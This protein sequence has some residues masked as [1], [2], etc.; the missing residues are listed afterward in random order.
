[1]GCFGGVLKAHTG[2]AEL[3]DRDHPGIFR[4]SGLVSVCVPSRLLRTRE[5]TG[6]QV[7]LRSYQHLA[8]TRTLELWASGTQRV[9]VTMPTGT[10]KTVVFSEVVKRTVGLG[11]RAIVLAHRKELIEQAAKTIHR[12]AGVTCDIEMAERWADDG[13]FARSPVVA[14]SKDTLRRRRLKRFNPA[15][16]GC[17]IIDEC[18]HA[19]AATYQDQIDHFC[20]NP[21]C[22]LLG[23]TATPDRADEIALGNVFQDV[24]LD[25]QMRDAIEDGWLV[26]VR[27]RP[28]DVRNID[29]SSVHTQNGDLSESEL[30]SAI[31]RDRPVQEMVQPMLRIAQGRT[32]V[33]CVTVAHAQHVAEVINHEQPNSARVVHGKTPDDER[34]AIF[35]DFG[36]GKF[37]FLVNVGIA[38][39]GWDD[40]A[41]DGKGVR[42]IAMMRATKSRSLFAQMCGRGTRPLPGTVDGPN[43]DTPEL[44]RAAI[45]ASSKPDV[46]IL[47]YRFNSGRHVLAHAADVLGGKAAH[48]VEETVLDAVKEDEKPDGYDVLDAIREAEVQRKLEESRRHAQRDR[49]KVNVDFEVKEL[50]PWEVFGLQHAHP[51]FEWAR[52]PAPASKINE[53]K[54][55]GYANIDGL[56]DAE[57]MTILQ[58]HHRRDAEGVNAEPPTERQIW[59]L[60]SLGINPEKAR[61][62]RQASA[63][64]AREMARGARR[65]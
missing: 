14:A 1:M 51:R 59:K 36:A 23:V 49:L 20:V 4:R 21:S 62:K 15:E 7:I 52:H 26:R 18:H 30:A 17:L 16:F 44:R 19:T 2:S 24:A 58:A 65:G 9:L 3:G 5:R 6:L 41:T 37:R 42:Y 64:I 33:F 57:A 10:G 31:D 45:A 53:L 39:E 38:T 27:V 46:T 47:D 61:S 60:R 25:Y 50:D 63:I 35:R 48:T 32:L 11:K 29:I 12:L 28:I 55:L 56:S 13:M 43:L 54:R 34:S 8:V 22:G 40:P